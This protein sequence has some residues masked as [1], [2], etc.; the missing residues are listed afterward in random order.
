M[1]RT[2]RLVCTVSKVYDTWQRERDTVFPEIFVIIVIL[3]YHRKNE[4]RENFCTRENWN[5]IIPLKRKEVAVTRTWATTGAVEDPDSSRH[6]CLVIAARQPCPLCGR[7]N[8]DIHWSADRYIEVTLFPFIIVVRDKWFKRK[9]LSLQVQ[10]SRRKEKGTLSQEL[11]WLVKTVHVKCAWTAR[12]RG[13][14]HELKD[15]HRLGLSR[16]PAFVFLREKDIL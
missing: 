4:T 13:T 8:G 9:V 14:A 11:V 12:G 2:C 1:L 5:F 7:Q 16:V 10:C 6:A 15:S 3:R